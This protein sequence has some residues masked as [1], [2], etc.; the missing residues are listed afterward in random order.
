M[1][2]ALYF[3]VVVALL[4]L[5]ACGGDS[6]EGNNNATADETNIDS[7]EV[8]DTGNGEVVDGDLILQLGETGTL[9]DVLGKYEITVHSVASYEEIEG[10]TPSNDEFTVVDMTLKNVGD[11][12]VNSEDIA[13]AVLDRGDLGGTRSD[14]KID[15]IDNFTEVI[16]PGESVSGQLLF[17]YLASD[18]FPYEIIFGSG[19]SSTPDEIKWQFTAD[20]VN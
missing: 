18:D 20:D 5:A 2:Y 6:D 1:K 4:S 7:E 13:T 11:S 17:D 16:D 3:F 8:E 10:H 9:E 19:V 14:N 12:A 15:E